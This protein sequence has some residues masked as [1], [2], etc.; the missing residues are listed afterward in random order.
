MFSYGYLEDYV[1]NITAVSEVFI[2]FFI[3]TKP[4]LEIIV[5]FTEEKNG[6]VG[7]L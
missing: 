1:T 7:K 5:F 3:I 4:S 6:R 2:S